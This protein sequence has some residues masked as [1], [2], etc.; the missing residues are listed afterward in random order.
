[1]QTAVLPADEPKTIAIA[2]EILR[3]SG[4]VAFPTDTVYGVGALVTNSQAIEKL[5]LAKGRD[6]NKA[7][8]VLFAEMAQ[9]SGV[10]KRLNK[11]A[12]LLAASFWPG[13]LTLVVKKHPDLPSNLTPDETIGVRMPDHL[14]TLRLLKAAGPLAVTSANLAGAENSTT[15]AQVLAQL[16]GKVELIQDGERTQGGQPSTVVD[17][18][19][20]KLRILRQGPVSETALLQTLAR[21]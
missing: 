6:F 14:I 4:L 3:S 20:R 9:L 19:S 18:T 5:Y 13:A 15:A 21:S 10:V 7:I 2:A 1:M 12:R 8:A 16:G 17:C 11:T